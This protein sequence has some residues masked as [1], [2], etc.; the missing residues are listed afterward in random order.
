MAEPLAILPGTEVTARGLRWEVVGTESLGLQTL[1]RLRGLDHSTQGAEVDVLSPLEEIE[2]IRHDL[3][4]ERAAHLDNWLA[5]HQAFLL[6][7]ALGPSAM[8]AVQPGRLRLEPY[9]LVPALRAIR[10]SRTR[11]LLADDVGLGKTVQAG[12]VLTELIARRLA[13]RILIVTPAGLLLNQWHEE[14]RERFG[15]RLRIIDSAALE[16][17]RRGQELGANPFDHISHGLVSIDFLKQ[18]RI[19]EQLERTS[20]DVVVIDEAHHCMDVGS[21]AEREDT[22]RR[23]LAKVLAK[24]CDALLLLTATPHD[25]NDRSFASLCELL[26]SSLVDG[27]G[28]LRGD[29]YRDHAVRRLKKHLRIPDPDSPGQTKPMFPEREVTPVP[30]VADAK[31][32]DRFMDLQ[33]G[34]LDLLAPQLKRA[35]RGN[36]YASVLAWF[37]LLKRSVSTVKACHTTLSAVAINLERFLK[38]ASEQ[39]EERRQRVRTLRDYQRKLDRFGAVTLEEEEEQCLL[40]AEDLGHQLASLQ[41]DIRRGSYRESKVADILARLDELSDL[42]EGALHQD[43]KLDALVDTI[44]SIRKAEPHANVLVYTEY[45]DSLDAA[46]ACLKSAGLAGVQSFRGTDDQNQRTATTSTFRANDNQILVSTDA[47]AEGLNLHYRC[48]HLIHL[49]LPFNPNRLEQR[50]GRI[51]RYGQTLVPMVRY[52]YLRGTFEERILLRLV[53]KWERQRARLTFVPNTLGVS[54]G[55]E[56]VQVKLLD[57]LINEEG[58]LFSGDP[59]LFDLHEEREN[60][61][62]DKATRELLEEIDRVL[63]GFRETARSCDWL[64][65]TG[66]NAEQRLS[67]EAEDAARVGEQAAHVDLAQFVCDAVLLENGQVVGSLDNPHFALRLP[68]HWLHD[69]D[70]LPGYDAESRL[71]RLTT[72]I[73][74]TADDKKRPVGYLGRAHPLVRRAL[75][76][77]R[78]LS[79]GEAVRR[80]LDTRASAVAAN[81]SEPSLL[82]TFLGRMASR[83][84]RELERV[85]AVRVNQ[86]ET[87]EFLDSADHWLGLADPKKALRTTDL[88]KKHYKNWWEDAQG[89]AQAAAEQGFGP[90]ADSFV[91]AHMKTLETEM[92]AQAEWLKKRADEITDAAERAQPREVGLFDDPASVPRVPSRSWASRKDPEQC[93]AAF[94]EDRSQPV[95]ARLEAEGVLRLYHDRL[96]DLRGRGDLRAPEIVPLGVLMLLPE[97]KS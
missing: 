93:L 19:V 57:G 60:E 47:S 48:H 89:Q 78:S 76:S 88:W 13:H 58:K 84:G 87:A 79:L 20:Y 49:E 12:L 56:F 94:H 62:A 24:S 26:D 96:A 75:D 65:G 5:Y 64:G 30:V 39:Q 34:L 36:D 8:V 29:R 25:G 42:A 9:Q 21:A 59:V 38:S 66:V 32:H 82:F 52:L 92:A 40:A 54:L 44:K 2:P 91:A 23:R 41:K 45:T 81:V 31:H 68:P 27:R 85:L 67:D 6:E 90:M 70:D 10:M 53:M 17:V 43:P 77:V 71:V 86:D 35:F 51:D 28:A 72:D 18:E 63:H 50:N 69:L 73:D 46:V 1:Y 95:R 61:G 15:L 97:A 4:P 37:V 80:G 16:E 11:L 83:R 7:Q 3:Q 33:R 14:M 22:Q 74:V 55:D